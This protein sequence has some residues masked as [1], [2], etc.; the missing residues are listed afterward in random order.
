MEVAHFVVSSQ[1][2]GDVC[3]EEEQVKVHF[4]SA[5][6]N[7]LFYFQAVLCEIVNFIKPYITA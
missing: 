2:L 5:N 3:T 6:K 1:V 7:L 4:P